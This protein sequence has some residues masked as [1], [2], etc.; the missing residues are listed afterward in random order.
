MTRVLQVDVSG[1]PIGLISWQ[2]AVCMLYQGSAQVLEAEDDFW[3]SPNLDIPRALIIQTED[4]IKLRPLR[5][6]YIIKRVLF[7]RD[8]W[9][10]QYCGRSITMSTGTK[11]HVK[12]QAAFEREGRSRTDANTWDNVTTACGPCNHKKG[13]RLPRECGMYPKTTPRKP[14]YIQTMWAGKGFHPI[15]AEYVAAYYKV[16]P[17]A[18]IA[19]EI[20]GQG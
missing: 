4:Y 1:R 16:D 3:K 13:D 15:Q 18:L 10:C 19:S 11:D 6:N 20:K 5:D 2:R 9:E 12:P 14:T 7:A 17:N 8:N